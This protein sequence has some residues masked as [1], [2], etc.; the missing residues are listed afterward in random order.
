MHQKIKAMLLD[1]SGV[2][3]I[4]DE[5]V[6]GAH[7]AIAKLREAGVPFRL[8]TNTTRSTRRQIAAKLE[9]LGFDFPEAW[10]FTPPMAVR[11]YLERHGLRPHLLVH[12]ALLDEFSDFDTTDPDVVVMGDAGE[13]FTYDRLNAAFRVLQGDA[14]FIAMG[15]NRYFREADGLSLDIGPFVKAL[16]YASGKTATIVGKPARAFFLEAVRDL[17]CEPGEVLM[18]GD[19]AQADVGGALNAGL[20]A[21][22]V[23]TGK[24]QA[25]DEEGIDAEGWRLIGSVA[26]LPGVLGV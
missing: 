13:Y 2:L 15:D 3:Y 9:K 4:G 1:L 22:L 19:D 18:V 11:Q 20:Q 8:V 25:G 17:G 16:E 26:D 12:P 7:E 24:Y 23:M 5:V 21:A 14:E 6:P 10:I